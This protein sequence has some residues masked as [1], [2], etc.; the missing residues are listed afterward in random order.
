MSHV[1]TAPDEAV[2]EPR[3]RSGVG[4]PLFLLVVM[5]LAA[6]V[7]G[8]AYFFLPPY[9][10]DRATSNLASVVMQSRMPDGQSR[11]ILRELTRIRE[12]ARKGALGMT[13]LAALIE[14]IR[15][16]PL[17]ACLVASAALDG[18][19]PPADLTPAQQEQRRGQTRDVVNRFLWGVANRRIPRPRVEETL[20]LVS[21]KDA[22]GR[23]A[24]KPKLDPN[25]I[26]DFLAS[27]EKQVKDA[28]IGP[29][30]G[31][32]DVAARLREDIDAA[33]KPPARPPTTPA[34]Q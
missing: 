7:V 15:T 27:V 32:A 10:A 28:G 14:E 21:Q 24:L 3:P 1:N 19:Q 8:F 2:L 25:D 31:V 11:A 9:I 18:F 16:G 6:A 5:A 33:L 22:E 30:P 26:R 13:A 4:W 12:A 29:N 20:N 17:Q 34:G 23:Y